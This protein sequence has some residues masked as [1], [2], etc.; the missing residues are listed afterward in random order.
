MAWSGGTFSRVDGA[1]GCATAEANSIGITSSDMD[2]RLNDAAGGINTALTKDGSNSPSAN[3]PM[4]AK[5]HTNVAN[6]AA[7][8]EYAAAG[9]VQDGALIYTSTTGSANVQTAALTPALG[10]YVDGQMVILKLGFTNTSANPTLNINGL[11]AKVV[12]RQGA[13]P[14][15]PGDM[16]NG[17]LFVFIFDGAQD[18]WVIMNPLSA[19]NAWTPAIGTLSGSVASTSTAGTFRVNDSNLV[20]FDLSIATTLSSGPSAAFTFTLPV[21][22]ANQNS[23][24]AGHTVITAGFVGAI[25]EMNSTTVVRVHRA[26][27]GQEWANN[28]Y[29][30]KMSGSYQAA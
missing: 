9:Q 28:P 26:E 2:N 22:A 5:K 17:E 27:A 23:V 21:T 11:G 20:T 13:R 15:Q 3:L 19:W 8:T 25:G 12:V 4:N 7:R 16:F 30:I 6:A 1:S 18:K 10:A 14:L 24:F 29:T